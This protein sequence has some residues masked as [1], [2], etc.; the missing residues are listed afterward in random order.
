[1]LP[2]CLAVVLS[3]R[4][5]VFKFYSWRTITQCRKMSDQVMLVWL[6]SPSNVLARL[7]PR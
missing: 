1:M 4:A 7:S 3:P 6:C 2:L 5:E